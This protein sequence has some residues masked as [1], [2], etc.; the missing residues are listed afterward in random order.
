MSAQS[1]HF[2]FAF[3]SAD[4]VSYLSTPITFYS[5]QVALDC[6]KPNSFGIF[7]IDYLNKCSMRPVVGRSHDLPN[8][9]LDATPENMIDDTT[10]EIDIDTISDSETITPKSI[11]SIP[12][13][14]PEPPRV[15]T[16]NKSAVQLPELWYREAFTKDLERAYKMTRN[17]KG[18]DERVKFWSKMPLVA[19]DYAVKQGLIKSVSRSRKHWVTLCLLLIDPSNG[20]KKSFTKKEFRGLKYSSKAKIGDFTKFISGKSWR[21][22][23]SGRHLKPYGDSYELLW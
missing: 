2:Q 19:E 10:S 15:Y 23:C 7:S 16:S 21:H 20:V 9:V 11:S 8:I 17:I 3:V 4:N 12:K 18:L 14:A 13:G 5:S 22:W 6:M 1:Q